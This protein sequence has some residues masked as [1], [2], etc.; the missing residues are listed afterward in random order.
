MNKREKVGLKSQAKSKLNR[1][2]LALSDEA[3]AI[4]NE[5]TRR[6]KANKDLTGSVVDRAGLGASDGIVKEL[7]TMIKE[8]DD[9]ETVQSQVSQYE[10]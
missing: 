8:I 4:I 5:A 7:K 1:K 10:T 6:M 3:I 9:V 2:S